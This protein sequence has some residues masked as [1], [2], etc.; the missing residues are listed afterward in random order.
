M[1]I[2]HNPQCDAAVPAPIPR[3]Y[4]KDVYRNQITQPAVVQ[5]LDRDVAKL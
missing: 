5:N 2:G 1:G 4:H 3:N